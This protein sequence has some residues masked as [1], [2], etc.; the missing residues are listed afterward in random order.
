MV[1]TNNKTV[2]NMSRIQKYSPIGTIV[3]RHIV[4]MVQLHYK[5]KFQTLSYFHPCVVIVDVRLI[6]KKL[7]PK[8]Y[9]KALLTL[10]GHT[11]KKRLDLNLPHTDVA[12]MM[13]VDEMTVIG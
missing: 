13:N 5:F 12:N 3:Q 9:P 11:R 6:A 8:A 7:I 2:S 10:G 4:V 1:V